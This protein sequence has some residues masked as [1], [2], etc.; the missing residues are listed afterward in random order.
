MK[1]MAVQ[2]SQRSKRKVKLRLRNNKYLNGNIAGRLL[3]NKNKISIKI[4]RFT[5][6]HLF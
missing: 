4:K 2:K 6:L 3:L 1:K 5:N